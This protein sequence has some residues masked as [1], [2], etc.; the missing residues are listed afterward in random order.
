MLHCFYIEI[1]NGILASTRLL[2][3]GCLDEPVAERLREAIMLTFG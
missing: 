3:I 2:K 1:N